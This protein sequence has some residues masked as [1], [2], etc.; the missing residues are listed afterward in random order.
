MRVRIRPQVPGLVSR[1]ASFDRPAFYALRP[2]AWRDYLTLLHPPY[3]L[4]HL[5]YVVLG[6]ALAPTP[7]YD[8]LGAT[9]LAFFLAVG[10]SAHAFDEI[11]GR[12]LKTRIPSGILYALAS[13]GLA[14][15]VTLGVVGAVLVSARLV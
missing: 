5:S 10:L 4:W 15:A 2:G 9:L 14:G 8:R 3:T 12:P 13:A 1:T 6:V 7:H 11:A